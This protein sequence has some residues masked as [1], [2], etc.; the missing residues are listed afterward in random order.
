MALLIVVG[1]PEVLSLDP[2]WRSFLNYIRRNNGC[3]GAEISWDYNEDVDVA[4]DYAGGYINARIDDMNALTA[5]LQERALAKAS[6][7]NG[8]SDDDGGN[9]DRPWKDAE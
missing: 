8:E 1:N 4:G 2:M 7:G 3:I 5:R 6:G 9:V